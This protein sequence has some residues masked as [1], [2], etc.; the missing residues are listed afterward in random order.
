MVSVDE[1]AEMEK[2]LEVRSELSDRDLLGGESVCLLRRLV[3]GR[4]C[5]VMT[6]LYQVYECKSGSFIC[7][8]EPMVKMSSPS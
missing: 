6:G 2:R 7:L 4:E 5:A 1:F 3:Q 8:R